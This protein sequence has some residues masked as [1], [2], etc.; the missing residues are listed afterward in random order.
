MHT[1]IRCAG[2]VVL[3]VVCAIERRLLQCLDRVLCRLQIANCSGSINDATLSPQI[4]LKPLSWIDHN[5]MLSYDGVD[6]MIRDQR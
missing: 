4:R 1:A 5:K 3:V 2:T 6:M